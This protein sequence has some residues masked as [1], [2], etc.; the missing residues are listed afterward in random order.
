MREDVPDA[1]RAEE[2]LWNV[3][4]RFDL[5]ERRFTIV[6]FGALRAADLR[7]TARSGRFRLFS[8]LFEPTRRS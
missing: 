2:C 4:G 5:P 6:Q 3:F 8:G 7:D 1:Q